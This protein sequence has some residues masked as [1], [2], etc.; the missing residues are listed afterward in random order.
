MVTAKSDKCGRM[1]CGLEKACG[2]TSILSACCARVVHT[3]P[4]LDCGWDTYATA[5]RAAFRV[6][7]TAKPSFVFDFFSPRKHPPPPKGFIL[8]RLGPQDADQTLETVFSAVY[9]QREGP[10][11]QTGRIVLRPCRTTLFALYLRHQPLPNIVQTV[12][13]SPTHCSSSGRCCNR[14][15]LSSVFPVL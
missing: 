7:R 1:K 11:I 4:S 6:A 5:A 3:A 15:F 8:A 13:S 9:E 2:S 10:A 12:V 14:H